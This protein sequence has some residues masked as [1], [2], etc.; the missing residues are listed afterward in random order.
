[1]KRKRGRRRYTGVERRLS[2][3]FFDAHPEEIF[4]LRK[5]VGWTRLEFASFCGVFCDTLRDDSPTVRRW[6]R[7]RARPHAVH[8]GKLVHLAELFHDQY[9]EKLSAIRSGAIRY[10]V[11]KPVRSEDRKTPGATN[12]IA[13]KA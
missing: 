6:E 2:N 10:Q 9:L 3:K 7:G 12:S 5:A 4:A 8:R 1:V 13:L 11:D